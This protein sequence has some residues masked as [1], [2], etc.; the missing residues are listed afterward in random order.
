MSWYCGV[1]YSND[2]I[3]NE[4]YTYLLEHLVRNTLEKKGYK[5]VEKD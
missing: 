5:D 1:E 2:N 4:H 3:N